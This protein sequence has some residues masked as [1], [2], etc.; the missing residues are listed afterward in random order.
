MANSDQAERA[1]STAT[2]SKAH[3]PAGQC[4]PS[5]LTLQQLFL[6]EMEATFWSILNNELLIFSES[7]Q[8]FE[9]EDCMQYLL[10]TSLLAKK[11]NSNHEDYQ[12][13]YYFFG[14]NFP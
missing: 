9:T 14:H 3:L 6:N 2:P 10:M 8:E 7:T 13:F 1:V 5:L 11:M 4:K 12:T